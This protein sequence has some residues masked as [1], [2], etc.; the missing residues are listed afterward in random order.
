MS[1]MRRL[2][3]IGLD[4]RHEMPDVPEEALMW[5]RWQLRDV[6]PGDTPQDA[7]NIALRIYEEEEDSITGI[8]PV[9]LYHRPPEEKIPEAMTRNL[10]HYLHEG[11]EIDRYIKP[12]VKNLMMEYFKSQ[13]R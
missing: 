3:K 8:S 1:P 12:S 13:N 10:G 4:P 6:L 9:R 11:G 2:P 5:T 7:L